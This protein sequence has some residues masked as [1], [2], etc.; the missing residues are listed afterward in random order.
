MKRVLKFFLILIFIVGNIAHSEEIQKSSVELADLTF[1]QAYEL[2]LENNNALKAY[3]EAIEAKKFEKRATLGEFAPK[4][5]LNSTYIHFSKDM[6]L[7]TKTPEPL[8]SMIPSINTFIQDSNVW[9]L[10]G[11]AVW[12]IFT[13]GKLLSNHAAARAKLEAS[14]EKYREIKDNLTLELVKRYYGLRLA[15]D[16]VEVRKQVAEGIEQHL[17]DARLLE[18]E[19]QV[20]C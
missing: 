5:V 10:G 8:S 18:K 2:M 20:H 9:G 13:G 4:V 6:T 1:R 3:N 16:V 15:R 14:N 7:T 12:N 19:G 17:N 11:G